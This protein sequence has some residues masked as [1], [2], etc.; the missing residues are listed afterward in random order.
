MGGIDDI[1]CARQKL[2]QV[3]GKMDRPGIFAQCGQIG[4]DL[5]IQQ[6]Q[7]L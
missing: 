5:P 3:T 4:G 7:F 1:V 2:I 6:A